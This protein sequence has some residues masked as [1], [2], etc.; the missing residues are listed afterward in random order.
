MRQR[1]KMRADG[2][3]EVEWPWMLAVDELGIALV[4]DELVARGVPV[5]Q[6][7]VVAL[8]LHDQ[9]ELRRHV[10]DESARRYRKLLRS[11]EPPDGRAKEGATRVKAGSS[12]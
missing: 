6:A 3:T 10:S 12:S 1:E 5:S 7:A 2:V 9:L 4:R 11:L 8:W